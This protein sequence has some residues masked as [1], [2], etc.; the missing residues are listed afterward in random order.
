MNDAGGFRGIERGRPA[1]VLAPMEGVTEAPMRGLLTEIGGFDYCVSEF[2]RVSQEIVPAKT[3]HNYVP[4]LASAGR[5]AAGAYVQVQLLGGDPERVAR[6]AL[7]A[8]R[9][10][11]PGIDLNFGCPAPTVNRNDGG[12]SLL[13]D[14]CR[15]GAIVRAVREAVPAHMP[16][17]AKLRLGWDDMNAIHETARRAEEGGASWITIHARTKVQGY[18]PPAH[19]HKIGEVRRE[20]SVPVVANGEIW[21]VEDFERCREVTG[22][23]H[24]MLGRGAVADP[25]LA[26]EVARRLG[27]AVA[28]APIEACVRETHWP[29]L[30]DRFVEISTAHD[31]GPGYLTRRIKQWFRMRN[32]RFP[33]PVFQQLKLAETYAQMKEI[34][35]AAYS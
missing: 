11:A 4:E 29:R 10:G 33:T 22:C 5:T 14:P 3:F 16:V 24:F 17:S 15:L 35:S 27:I 28:D 18:I 30:V 13:R 20:V 7:Q 26:R 1:V 19:W 34:L 9:V 31:G 6:S 25:Y 12:A 32:S 2:V 21:T 8:V 23:E